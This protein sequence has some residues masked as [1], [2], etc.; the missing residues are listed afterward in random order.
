M[1]ADILH[2][3]HR[4]KSSDET[5]KAESLQTLSNMSGGVAV[6]WQCICGNFVRGKRYCPRCQI[7]RFRLENS[8]ILDYWGMKLGRTSEG[9]PFNLPSDILTKHTM[10]SGQ[11]GSGK[12]RFAMNLVSKVEKSGPKALIIDVEGEWKNII[13]NLRKE[14]TYCAVGKNL[15]I[16]PFDLK[17]PGLIRELFRETVFKGIEKEY[18]DLSAQMNFVLQET[19][20]ESNS[21]EELIHNIKSYDRQKLTALQ[22]TKT[23]LLVRL[24]PFL[25]SPLKEIFLCTKSNPDF[26]TIDQK[27]VVIDLHELDSLVAYNS[28]L[29]LIYN[30]FT[31]YFLRKMLKREQTEQLT[32]IFVADEAQL[33]VPRILHK[34]IV[35]ESWP[36]TEFA[37]RLR[38]R[39]CGIVLITQSPSN[40]ER[41]IFKNTGTKISF[42]LQHQED[43]KIIAESVGFVDPIEAEYLSDKFVRLPNKNAIVSTIG[44]E[45]FLIISDDF[46]IRAHEPETE[47]FVPEKIDLPRPEENEF[48]EFLEKQPFLPV[49]QRRKSLGWDD[50]KY[51]SV[52][53]SLLKKKKIEIQKAKLGRGAPIILYQKPK[54]IPSVR[55]QFYV[56]WISKKIDGIGLEIRNNVKDGPDIMISKFNSVVEVELGTSDIHYNI[57][58]N[59]TKYDA[60]VVT[61]DDKKLL[62]SLKQENKY[63]NV[64]FLLIQNVPDFFEKIKT[65]MN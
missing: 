64:L 29:R 45:P 18:T 2:V 39:G 14:T 4:D 46:P 57:S 63:S 41:D 24:D 13:P 40:I 10:I 44:H 61:S 55:H 21:I 31:I 3:S 32:N 23:A 59:V 51:A 30:I 56:D 38:K 11:T 49:R 9:L 7:V 65:R 48:L 17:D 37:T 16:N 34:M 52:V 6:N 42:R 47:N 5:A 1:P 8:P 50:K 60:V 12:T 54:Q 27:N 22:K 58:R 62:E 35:T 53:K 33:L 20:K 26:T 28:E 19:I 25:R 36:A 15:R 43:I